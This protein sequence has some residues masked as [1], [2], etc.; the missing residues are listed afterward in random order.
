M[1]SLLSGLE[2]GT[3]DV[4]A[5]E[6]KFRRNFTGNEGW[7]KAFGYIRLKLN[8]ASFSYTI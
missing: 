8:Q 6:M 2:K 5:V 4:T 1:E 3:G 7:E